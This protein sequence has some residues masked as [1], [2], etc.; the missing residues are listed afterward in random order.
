MSESRRVVLRQ[1]LA[2]EASW[3]WLIV[4]LGC[5]AGVARADAPR[6]LRPISGARVT[7]QRPLLRWAASGPVTVELCRDR[8]CTQPVESIEAAAASA[9]PKAA[10]PPGAVFW[11]V[12]APSGASSAVWSMWVGHRS[13]PLDTVKGLWL[14]GKTVGDLDSRRP[15]RPFRSSSA[16]KPA[17]S[18]SPPPGM[19]TATATTI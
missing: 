10:L 1:R 16:T 15:A 9:T 6:L 18:G 17:F 4:A 2:H 12:R 5:I 19:S 7:S 8:A 14:E 13:A 11:R 3:I